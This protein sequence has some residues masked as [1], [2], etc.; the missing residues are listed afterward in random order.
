MACADVYAPP[1]GRQPRLDC[2]VTLQRAGAEYSHSLHAGSNDKPHQR[3]AKHAG[4]H[5]TRALITAAS[6]NGPSATAVEQRERKVWD[7]MGAASS[8]EGSGAITL[9]KSLSYGSGA[10]PPARRHSV[11]QEPRVLV[12]CEKGCIT[13]ITVL[14]QLAQRAQH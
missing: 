12:V 5:A 11:S 9:P 4:H 7:T 13:T 2:T 3:R 1:L 14:L 8:D 6:A 10:A